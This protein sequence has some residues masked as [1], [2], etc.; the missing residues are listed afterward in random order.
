[1][2]PPSIRSHCGWIWAALH[3]RWLDYNPLPHQSIILK[4]DA[5][6]TNCCDQGSAMMQPLFPRSFLSWPKAKGGHF[7]MHCIWKGLP[8][9]TSI[10]WLHVMQRRVEGLTCTKKQME[11]VT[12][13]CW[14]V[15]VVRSISWNWLSTNAGNLQHFPL[16]SSWL[17]HSFDALQ[18]ICFWWDETKNQENDWIKDKRA[19]FM[20]IEHRTYVHWSILSYNGNYNLS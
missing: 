6:I 8:V 17:L 7:A 18:P 12:T 3:R 1:M 13:S 15:L 11:E 16:V 10:N 2:T 20:V 19:K 4:D 14:W 5:D 9:K